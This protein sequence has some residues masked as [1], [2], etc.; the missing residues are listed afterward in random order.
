MAGPIYAIAR[1]HGDIYTNLIYIMCILRRPMLRTD[2]HQ[3]LWSDAL[4]AALTWRREP[5]LIRRSGRGWVLR[6]RDEPE[7]RFDPAEHD[8]RARRE[9]LRR[10]GI[11]RALLCISGPLGIE[12][13]ERPAAEPLLEAHNATARELGRGFGIWGAVSLRP[14]DPDDVDALLDAGAVGISL[15]AGALSGPDGVDRCGALLERLERRDAPLLVHPGPSP[16]RAQPYADSD[17]PGWWPAMT[18]YVADMNAAWHAFAAFG[19]PV[20]PH[21]RVVFAMLA[22]GAPLHAERLVARGGPAAAV[23]DGGLFYDTSSYGVRAIDALV[24]C[25]GID[26]LVHGSDRPVV[27]ATSPSLLGPAAREAMTSANIAR[28]L[29]E[30]AAAAAA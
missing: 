14:P 18:R 27:D 25:V 4:V 11:E 13:L 1:I 19:R 20:H 29:G 24:R 23:T 5:P 16:W 26:Q 22:G 21:L 8:P 9:L 30:R 7:F 12:A 15:P 2:V 17:A 28:L 3:H 10:D 6:L